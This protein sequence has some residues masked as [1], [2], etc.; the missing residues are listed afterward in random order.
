MFVDRED[1]VI[2]SAVL[3]AVSLDTKIHRDTVCLDSGASGSVFNDTKWFDDLAELDRPIKIAAANGGTSNLALGGTVTL[4]CNR[5]CGGLTNLVIPDAVYSINT[6]LNLVSTGQLRRR[7]AVFN[8]VEDRLVFKNTGQEIA[9]RLERGRIA[10][11]SAELTVHQYRNDMRGSS[12][13]LFSALFHAL[14][15][16]ACS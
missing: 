15:A 13:I 9:Q 10:K 1:E 11:Y 12:S 6:P 4:S 16:S 8:G 7:G 14:F 3:G 5:S 2:A